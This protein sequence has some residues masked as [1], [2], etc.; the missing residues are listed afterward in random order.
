MNIS[1]ISFIHAIILSLA[2]I[3]VKGNSNI[4]S[5]YNKA[6]SSL[7]KAMKET[8]NSDDK[9]CSGFTC[10]NGKC[11]KLRGNWKEKNEDS[12]ESRELR[13]ERKLNRKRK[14]LVEGKEKNEREER[15]RKRK[16]NGK[17]KGKGKRKHK[18]KPKYEGGKP[19][20]KN[21][22]TEEEKKEAIK[23]ANKKQKKKEKEVFGVLKGGLGECGQCIKGCN[24]ES[25]MEGCLL[26]NKNCGACAKCIKDSDCFQKNRPRDCKEECSVQCLES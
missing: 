1:K 12:S 2:F 3:Q 8:C 11:E 24:D 9:C 25:C 22:K 7:C 10:Y 26:N 16:G 19:K 5:V 15:K 17:V 21:K 14:K 23:E 18:G 6:N 13:L 20:R 4:R